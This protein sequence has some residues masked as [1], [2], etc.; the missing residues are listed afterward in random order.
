MRLHT[1][2]D[3]IDIAHALKSAKRAGQV[4]QDVTFQDGLVPHG[5]RTHL[6]AYEIQLGT[7]EKDSLPAGYTDQNGHK[8]NVRRFKNTGD[9]GASSGWYSPSV[10]AATWDEWGWFIAYVFAAD[11]DARFGH[12]AS[13]ADFMTKTKNAFD[14][15]PTPE[16]RAMHLTP[17]EVTQL[18][19]ALGEAEVNHDTVREQTGEDA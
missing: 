4:A 18:E 13:Y 19:A 8:L 15:E 5:S 9:S 14:L 1:N 10:W 12:Y 17:R 6:R 11:P 7:F 3:Y 16:Y 2:L